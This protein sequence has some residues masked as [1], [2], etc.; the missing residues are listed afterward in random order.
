MNATVRATASRAEHLASFIEARFGLPPASAADLDDAVAT[1]ARRRGLPVAEVINQ[2]LVFPALLREIAGVLGV[3]E[4]YFFRH[5]DALVEIARLVERRLET[6]EE[7]VVWS[8]GCCRGEELF[9]LA[10]TLDER[11]APGWQRRVRLMGCDVSVESIGL[12]REGV[13]GEWSFRGGGGDRFKGTAFVPAGPGQWRV[14]DDL[15]AAARF[16]HLSVQELAIQSAP[17][18][19]DVL[20]FRNVAV[21]FTPSVMPPLFEALNAVLAPGGVLCLAATDPLPVLP[22]LEPS[23]AVVGMYLRKQPGAAP[24]RQVSSEPARRPL[25]PRPEHQP[26]HPPPPAEPVLARAQRMADGGHVT[27]AL[28]LLETEGARACSGTALLRAQILAGAQRWP[29]ARESLRRLLYLEPHHLLGRYWLAL[30]LMHQREAAG[31][32]TQVRE[33]ARQLQSRRADEALEDGQTTAGSLAD[34][35]RRLEGELT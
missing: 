9:S 29:E 12:A 34:E 21:Y 6:R 23:P 20:L 33:L 31:A 5:P 8:A 35:L 15:R 27:E 13:Y 25:A 14:R 22:S 24:A 7:V 1:V 28:A 16:E 19:I 30:T 2:A 11:L 17:A 32:L 4:T 18:S 26:L 3:S 10:I